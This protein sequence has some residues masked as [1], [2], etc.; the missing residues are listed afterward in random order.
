M[1]YSSKNSLGR[2]RIDARGVEHGIVEVRELEDE[3]FHELFARALDQAAIVVRRAGDDLAF[4]AL[5]VG[6]LGQFVDEGL[7]S[8][9][10]AQDVRFG[11]EQQAH[12]RPQVRRCDRE[13]D[14]LDDVDAGRFEGRPVGRDRGQA[15]GIAL[16]AQSRGLELGPVQPQPFH[17]G[18]V[19]DRVHFAGRDQIGRVGRQVARQERGG[20]D[21]VAVDQFLHRREGIAAEHEQE[22]DA[23]LEDQ[24][25]GALEGE[26]GIVAAIVGHQLDLVAPA[27]EREAAGGVDPVGPD[28]AAVEARLA[29][30]ADVAGEGAQKAHFDVLARADVEPRHRGRYGQ[31]G[32]QAFV[33]HGVLGFRFGFNSIRFGARLRSLYRPCTRMGRA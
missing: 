21:L 22:L 5:M 33:R 15:E 8:R 11:F 32:G 2:V 10:P 6:R 28:H 26:V 30:G 18:D 27:A 13:E 31:A 9:V 17:A 29:P 1:L 3:P 20:Q 4:E 12:N 7:I 16:R 19:V 24:L 25:A 14:L 23:F